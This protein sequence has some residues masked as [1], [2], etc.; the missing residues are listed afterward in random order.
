MNN[1][2]P[3]LAF[4]GRPYKPPVLYVFEEVELNN[5]HGYHT[6]AVCSG[7]ER[8]WFGPYKKSS[9]VQ[10][11]SRVVKVEYPPKEKP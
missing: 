9:E 3:V 7:P 8:D 2:D 4:L 6:L 5:S 11:V 1:D 10:Y